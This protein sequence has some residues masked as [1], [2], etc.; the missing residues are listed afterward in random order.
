MIGEPWAAQGK[1][2]LEAGKKIDLDSCQSCHGPTGKSDSDMA[3]YLKLPPVNL[4][5]QARTEA[6]IKIARLEL[7]AL[8]EE[9]QVEL[10]TIHAK[11]DQL[12]KVEGTLMLA[13]IKGKRDAMAMLTPEQRGKDRAQREKMK[14]AGEG[15]HGSGMGSGG[16]E[17]SKGGDHASGGQHQ[18]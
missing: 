17:G 1:G 8:L 7:H 5:T 16:H 18:H 11:V 6:E 10:S 2:S 9:E 12:K 3:A 13:A 14:S 15:Q 4:R